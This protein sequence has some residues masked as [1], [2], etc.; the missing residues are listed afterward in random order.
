MGMFLLV[1][2]PRRWAMSNRRFLLSLERM[3]HVGLLT[4]T[5]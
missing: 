2:W 1:A 4:V 5:I 3:L